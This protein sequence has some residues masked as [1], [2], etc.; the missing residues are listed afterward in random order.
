M[1]VAYILMYNVYNNTYF[2][3]YINFGEKENFMNDRHTTDN[4]QLTD[5][6]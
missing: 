4:A 2:F 3:L 5:F 1:Y 6:A